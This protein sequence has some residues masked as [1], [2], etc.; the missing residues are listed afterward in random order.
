VGP[1][2]DAALT[3]NSGEPSYSASVVPLAVDASD[4]NLVQHGGQDEWRE[5]TAGQGFSQGNLA[6]TGLGL[7]ST[8]GADKNAL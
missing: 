4:W 5:R 8:P 6:S 2:A 3:I 1:Q 7:F